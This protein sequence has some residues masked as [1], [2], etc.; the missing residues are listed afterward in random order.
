MV[1]A[2]ANLCV[3]VAESGLPEPARQR[4]IERFAARPEFTDAQV[5]EAV[6]EE[7]KYIQSVRGGAHVQ[8]LGEGAFIE[9][10][11]DFGAKCEQMMDALF[12]PANRSVTSLKECYIAVTGDKRVT[13]RIENCDR[14]RLREAAGGRF[15]E[16]VDSATWANALGNAIRRALGRDYAES[17]RYDVWRRLANVVPRA[18]F[19][20]NE[21]TRVGGYGD[22]PAV[23]QSAPYTALASPTDEKASYAVTKRG[24]TEDVTLE[25]IKNDDVGA[26]MR[27][28]TKLSRAA[29]RTLSKFVLDFLATN[30]VIF[31]TKT[32]FHAD[33][34]NLGSTALSAATLAAA[35]LRVLKQTELS[36]AARIGIP[37][38]NLWVPFD[39]EEAAFDLFRRATNNDTDFV[40]SLQMN[41][42]PV[43]YWTD[44]N[45]WY[46]TCDP[47][48]VP[49]VEIGFLD[50]NE[51]PELFVQD[52]PTVGSLF[53]HDKITYKI[54]HIYGGNVE[55][56]RGMDGN[57]V[58]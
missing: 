15:V 47:A 53:T 39:L 7:K 5:R 3:R 25:T 1:E 14:S 13:G 40:E 57:I 18:D 33:H 29:K 49:T 35:R 54:R 52:N 28:P 19:R 27:I 42:I 8:D 44:G 12:D 43:W 58:A 16:S 55:D 41:V 21:L 9:S 23:A 36:S 51:E 20:T 24:G 56:Y 38:I 30:P 37:P 26:V 10:G 11:E 32:L 4:L 31:D 17:G 45:N 46:A 48:E 2:R 50:G 34:G 6:A 22:L